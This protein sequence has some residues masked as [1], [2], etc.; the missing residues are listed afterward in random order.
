[1]TLEKLQADMIAAM[2][3]GD[4]RRKDVLSGAVAAVKKA[5]IDKRMKDNIVEE[6]VDE[7]LTKEKKTI[8]EMID[9]CPES[10][11]D[12]LND[13]QQKY[14]I[15][16]EYAPVFITDRS[17]LRRLIFQLCDGIE[18]TKNNKGVVMKALSAN[19]KGKADMKVVQELVNSL[20]V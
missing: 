16:S 10:R 17:T 4:K 11:E 8:K 6:L 5:A 1:M 14:M 12:L 2:K 9:T 7:V 18:L 20:L 13:Y 15:I 3:S 19:L